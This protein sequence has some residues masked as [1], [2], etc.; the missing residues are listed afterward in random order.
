VSYIDNAARM[1]VFEPGAG[2]DD[3]NYSQNLCCMRIIMLLP[4]AGTRAG[5]ATILRIDQ[6]EV[7]HGLDLPSVQ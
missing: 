6:Q 4:V 1:L 7:V 2:L 5:W 3:N